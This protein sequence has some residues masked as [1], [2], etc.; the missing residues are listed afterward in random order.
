MESTIL[1]SLN[2]LS[3]FGQYFIGSIILLV[4]FIALYGLITPYNEYKLIREGKTAPAISF[5]GSVL[6]Y[7][8]PMC[9]AITHS[10]SL[11][12][13]VLWAVIAMVVQILV[14]LAMKLLFNRLIIDV[15]EDKLGPAIL[16]A[17]LSISAG[18]INA[19]CM[20]Y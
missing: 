8:F 7:T 5:G 17:I 19:A 9:S 16:L 20:T 1:Q 13:M 2:G 11:I 14:F 15:V 12:D 3:A 6:G 18:L 10:V 4:I